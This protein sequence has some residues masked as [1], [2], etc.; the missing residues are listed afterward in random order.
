M[1]ATTATPEEVQPPGTMDQAMPTAPAAA[2]LPGTTAPVTP[3]D[4]GEAQ[5]R[6]AEDPVPGMALA[7]APAPGIAS[8]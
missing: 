8:S 7:V 6:G 1:A 3:P 2:P 4:G 5:P